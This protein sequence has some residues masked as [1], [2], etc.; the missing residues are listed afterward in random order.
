[1]RKSASGKGLMKKFCFLFVLL[2][3]TLP[4]LS[5]EQSSYQ[6]TD[7][8]AEPAGT[9]NE[10][11]AFSPSV[12]ARISF[13]TPMFVLEFAPIQN[14]V[15]STGIRIWPSFWEKNDQGQTIYNP[16]FNPRMTLEPRW[17]FTQSYRRSQG[18]RTDFYSGWYLGLPFMMTFPELDYSMGTVMGFQCSFGKH[19]YWNLSL[20]PGFSYEESAFRMVATGTVAFGVILN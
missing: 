10:N 12:I 7:R 4:L 5:Q 13:I 17:F 2:L 18:R 8:N 20:G 15:F 16:T 11:P 19:W 6:Y 1:M 3:S 9:W 14:F